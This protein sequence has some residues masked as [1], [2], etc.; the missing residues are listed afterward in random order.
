MRIV[1][2]GAMGRMGEAIRKSAADSAIPIP[3]GIEHS[4]HEYVGKEVH[5]LDMPHMYVF[6]SEKIDEALS[7]SDV[8]IDFTSIE[9]TLKNIEACVKANVGIVIGTT[10]FSEAQ[11]QVIVESSKKIPVVFSPNMSVGVNV[12]FKLVEEAVKKMPG[13]DIEIVELHHNKKKDSPSGTAAKLAEV[14]A[15]ARGGTHFLYGREGIIGERDKNEIGVMAVRGGDIV[16]EHTVYLVGNGERLELTHMAQSRD[17]F[18]NG[19]VR[20][21]VWLEGKPAGLYTM[22]DVLGL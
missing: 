2:A 12:L 20:A 15:Q 22:K 4:G 1:L 14:A 5:T 7:Q 9:A 21:A 11:K 8:L 17:N 13:Y 19:A 6:S 16:G 3:V 10:G 18:A